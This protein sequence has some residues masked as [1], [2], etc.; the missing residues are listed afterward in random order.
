MSKLSKA[1]KAFGLILKKPHLLN[2]INDSEEAMQEYVEKKYGLPE[3]LKTVSIE[4]FI[5]R[6]EEIEPYGFLEGSS[7]PTDF[8]LL[9]SIC[10]QN[11]VEDYLEIGT[12]RGESAANVAPLVKNCYT[13]NLPD[14]EMRRMGMEEAYIGMHRCFSKQVEN[15]IHL[16]AD[17][18]TFD[19]TSLNKKF[20]LIFLDGDHHTESVM[21][22][23]RNAFRLL[24]DDNSMIVWH[25][26]GEGTETTRFSV[27][28]GILDGC[29]PE[30]IPHLYRVS[31][32]LCAI[33]TKKE[34]KAEI[35][36]PNSVPELSFKVKITVC[37]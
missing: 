20:D 26:T 31:N 25:D 22:D 14:D 13:L 34:L 1:F 8:A 7:L 16:K 15:I 11:Q 12:W 30:H 5:S 33:F 19:F 21:N 32:S 36:K 2:L 3:G 27:L 4:Q 17:S 9:R 37:K 24:K 28:A 29:P 10:R 18:Q 6:E 35:V 23:T